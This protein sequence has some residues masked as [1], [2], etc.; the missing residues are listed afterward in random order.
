MNCRLSKQRTLQQDQEQLLLSVRWGSIKNCKN[1]YKHNFYVSCFKTVDKNI[2]VFF[3]LSL[4]YNRFVFGLEAMSRASGH[5]F[6]RTFWFYFYFF[7]SQGKHCGWE[8][9]I[10]MGERGG[11]AGD[12]QRSINIC[13]WGVRGQGSRT[14]N[15]IRGREIMDEGEN[16]GNGQTEVDGDT[17]IFRGKVKYFSCLSY[18]FFSLQFVAA[19]LLSCF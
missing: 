19:F 1:K 7:S 13:G 18:S 15:T 2:K 9:S 16:R 12:K 17:S 14:W 4:K 6:L 11:G 5:F 8:G 10:D 3:F